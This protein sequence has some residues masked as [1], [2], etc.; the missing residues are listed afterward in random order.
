MIGLGIVS[1]MIA[2]GIGASVNAYNYCFEKGNKI[3]GIIAAT[4]IAITLLIVAFV[5]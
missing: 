1:C 3:L 5:L 4:A 2:A